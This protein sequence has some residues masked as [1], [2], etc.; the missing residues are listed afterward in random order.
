LNFLHLFK[1]S[2]LTLST[3]IAKGILLLSFT[4]LTKVLL[5]TG[6]DVGSKK[7]EIID[8]ANPPTVCQPSVLDDYPISQVYGTS[9]GLLNTT[10]A[11]ICGGYKWSEPAEQL[12][13]CF[14]ITANAI[15][16][17]QKLTLPRSYAASVVLN[18][19]TL[20][21]TGGY[22]DGPITTMSTEFVQLTGTRPGPDLPLKIRYEKPKFSRQHF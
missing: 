13:D 6:M 14:A 1:K 18:G 16:S 17:K 19:N 15:E 4:G 11:L 22:L 10:T 7:I 2:Y 12:D 5:T 8:F 21:L 9:G 20:W 3:E